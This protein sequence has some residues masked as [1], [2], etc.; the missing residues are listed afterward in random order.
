[1][2]AD[3]AGELVR[4][5]HLVDVFTSGGRYAGD[6]AFDE[7]D[8]V[9]VVRVREPGAGG[10]IAAWGSFLMAARR[11]VPTAQW[12]RALVLTDPPFLVT[13]ALHRRRS[14]RRV[15]WW[16]MDL[17]PEALVA[18][19]TLDEHG[20]VARR[21]RAVNERSIRLLD[22]VITL[23]PSQTERLRT[24]PSWPANDTSF[25][26]EEPPWDLRDVGSARRSPNRFVA[27]HSLQ[28]R[29]VALYAGNMGEAHG[30]DELV[31]AARLLA[32]DSASRWTF[33]FVVRGAGRAALLNATRDLPNV[34]VADYVAADMTA[35]M[36][37]SA[38]VHLATMRPGWEGVV[39][40][41]KLYG[42]LATSGRVLFIG[43]P[44]SDSAR[45]VTRHGAG[46]V[47]PPGSPPE[48]VVDALNRLYA[49]PPAE[50]VLDRGGP[51][52]VARFV[53]ADAEAR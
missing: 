48:A 44:A 9:R 34:I 23:G 22:G 19:G 52:R 6:G 35:E 31:A 53:T 41:S 13:A 39:V 43:P 50:R 51:A 36:L 1:M 18:H 37:A 25:L 12:D 46:A 38:D 24:Y 16:T 7:V 11:R 8:G 5:G 47:L 29:R 33:V 30:F 45:A 42:A 14:G 20:I 49:L 40:P 10:R 3:V 32:L 26:L 4:Q 27:A 15:Y 17:Y 28:G 2:L 21:L